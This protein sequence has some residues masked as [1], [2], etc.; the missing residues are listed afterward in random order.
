MHIIFIRTFFI[1]LV[2][3]LCSACHPDGIF[4]AKDRAFGIRHDK[5]LLEY[6][7]VASN[8]APYHTAN[9]PD[10]SSVVNFTY[11]L[12]GSQNHE[13][14]A[15]GV[16]VDSLW[17]L[18]AGHNF[19]TSDDQSSPALVSGIQVNFGIDPENPDQTRE[20]AELVF[21]PTWLDDDDVYGKANDLCLVK[22]K[23]PVTDLPFASL[24]TES[25][26]PL[27]ATVW[28]A[29]YGDYSREPGQDRDLYSKRHAIENVLD[30]VI[31]DINSQNQ[32]GE[33]YVGGLVAFDFDAPD[34]SVN[35]LGDDFISEDE[36]LLGGGSSS[37]V[38]REFE[39]GTVEGDSG[40]P[41]FVQIDG[42]WQVIGILSGG[43]TEPVRRHRDGDYGDISIFTRVSTAWEWLESVR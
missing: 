5:S 19:F 13:Y 41:L 18:T 11:S 24:S 6:E 43:A 16:L 34:S 14:A 33:T 2:T 32:A 30:R 3:V 26:E 17:V 22:L 28:Y 36:P 39:G 7:A 25:N 12:D 27:N 37:P 15:S 40:G 4:G 8:A 38:A 10:F 23:T 21:H 35:S 31:G 1:L 42:R 9:Y 20:V 29:G